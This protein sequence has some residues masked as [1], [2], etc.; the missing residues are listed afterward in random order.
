MR[1]FGNASDIVCATGTGPSGACPGGAGSDFDPNTNTPWY[2]SNLSP[3]TNSNTTPPGVLCVAGNP[4]CANGAD[5]TAIASIRVTD[6]YNNTPSIGDSA[7]CGTSSS[8]SG[9]VQ[10]QDFLVPVVCQSNADSTI[11]SYCGANTTANALV[12]GVVEAGKGALVEIGQMQVFDSGLDGIRNN[13][14]DQLFA[15]QGIVLP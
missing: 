9:T 14:D 3:G 10:D 1:L 8:C 2:T 11:G 6:A 4:Q 13:S 7:G 12:P 5:L 15:V